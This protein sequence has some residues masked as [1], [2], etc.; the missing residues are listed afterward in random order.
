MARTP[1]TLGPY[2][3]PLARTPPTFGPYAAPLALTPR[4]PHRP[5][6]SRARMCAM[7]HS[8]HSSVVNEPLRTLSG[9]ARPAR[10]RAAPVLRPESL[11]DRPPARLSPAPGE[12]ARPASGS[13]Q[14]CA[15][16]ACATGLRL[17]SVLRPESLRDRPPARLSPAP[18]ELARPASGSPQSC[19]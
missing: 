18:G 14:S 7:N 13:P 19:A 12:L 10:T 15:R 1:P 9:H 3:A 17:A 11:R 8:P 4:Q 16:R 2:A 5:Q 6:Q